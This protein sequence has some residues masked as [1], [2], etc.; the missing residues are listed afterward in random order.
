MRWGANFQDQQWSGVAPPELLDKLRQEAIAAWLGD[1]NVEN[2]VDGNHAP[3]SSDPVALLAACPVSPSLLVGTESLPPADPE[4]KYLVNAPEFLASHVNWHKCCPH[5]CP[6]ACFLRG[7]FTNGLAAHQLLYEEVRHPSQDPYDHGMEKQF[8]ADKL[9]SLTKTGV[10]E[11]A[12]VAVDCP[13]FVV[14][15]MKATLTAEEFERVVHASSMRV[16]KLEH[17]GKQRLVHDLRRLNAATR[18]WPFRYMGLAHIRQRMSMGRVAASI[19]IRSAFHHL[20]LSPPARRLFGISGTGLRY[21]R[22]PFGWKL[23]PV[24]C[25]VFTAELKCQ[26]KQ[27]LEDMGL[28]SDLLVYVDDIGFIWT[29]MPPPG[30]ME[31]VLAHLSRVGV[32]VAAEKVVQPSKEM[33]YLGIEWRLGP[34]GSARVPVAKARRAVAVLE[35]ALL[36]GRKMSV[37]AWRSIV[38]ML[39]WYSEARWDMRPTLPV[40]YQRLVEQSR[41]ARPRVLSELEKTALRSWQTALSGTAPIIRQPHARRWVGI[42][43]DASIMDGVASWGGYAIDMQTGEILRMWQGMPCAPFCTSTGM[44]EL[45]GVVQAC[46]WAVWARPDFG[47]CCAC[48]AAAAVGAF[49]RGYMSKQPPQMSELIG[50]LF[51]HRG[52]RRVPIIIRWRPRDMH[53]AADYLSRRMPP[54]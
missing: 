50:V 38:G 29:S 37:S 8:V 23:A 54:K 11:E 34:N 32:S 20:P 52:F 41:R 25:C 27:L 21:T 13:V 24:L 31:A 14:A 26:L 49:R 53:T 44:A 9:V 42:G 30:V 35:W 28:P 46:L 6:L 45:Y 17:A 3:S 40:I 48:D 15:K 43:T 5:A 47:I 39:N 22:L 18:S 4:H 51:K 19:D 36:P 1:V 16:M 12:P 2:C 33:E 7:V 10:L